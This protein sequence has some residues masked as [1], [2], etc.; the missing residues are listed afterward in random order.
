[1]S[2]IYIYYIHSVSNKKGYIGST[3]NYKER[4]RSHIS[5]L[6]NKKHVNKYLQNHVNKYSIKD[7]KFE[8]LGKYPI[9]YRKKIEQFYINCKQVNTEFNCDKSI[10]D[11]SI[12]KRKFS[13]NQIKDLVLKISSNDYKVSKLANEFNVSETTIYNIIKN[14]KDNTLIFNYKVSE[15]IV[16]KK[17]KI[18]PEHYSKLNKEQVINLINDINSRNFFPKDLCKKYGIS[19]SSYQRIKRGVSWRELSHLIDPS[20]KTEAYRKTPNVI[21]N[22]IIEKYKEFSNKKFSKKEFGIFLEETSS[23][24]KISTSHLRNIINEIKL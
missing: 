22:R 3:V 15:R 9:N 5:S 24:Y 18:N 10:K 4:F 1:M 17:T 7:L 8:V 13:E 12:I 6:K 16:Y 2:F 19:M 11:C 14:Y 20:I 23:F 21:K